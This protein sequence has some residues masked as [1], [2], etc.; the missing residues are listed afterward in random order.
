MDVSKTITIA[1]S[2]IAVCVAAV[3]VGTSVVAWKVG[4]QK[5]DPTPHD[6]RAS[7]VKK[8]CME[9]RVVAMAV[10]VDGPGVV[11]IEIDHEMSCRP[12]Y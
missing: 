12:N 11:T 5:A 1:T 4:A 10:S 9:G 2:F 3:A 8:L 7:V 6:P